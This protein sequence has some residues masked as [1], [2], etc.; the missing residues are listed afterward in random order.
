MKRI[1]FVEDD[2]LVARIYTPKLT[3]AG[4]EVQ[5]AEDGLLAVQRLREFKPDLVVLDLLMPKLGG[6]E[7]LKFIR[8]ELALKETRVIVFSNSFLGELLE[9]VASIGVEEALVKAS[10]TPRQLVDIINNVF[11]RPSRS[12]LAPGTVATN[13]AGFNE[14][15]AAASAAQ[16]APTAEQPI[17]SAPSASITKEK[18]ADHRA[19]DASAEKQ[20]ADQL[21]LILQSARK[22]CGEFLEAGNLSLETRKLEDLHR[23]IGFV[24]QALGMAGRRRLAHLAGALEAMLFDLQEKNVTV[25]D[26]NRHTIASAVAFL[27]ERIEQVTSEN[28]PPSPKKIL[29]V[30]DD[31]VSNRAAVLALNRAG[32][33]TMS[34]TDPFDTLKRLQSDSFGLVL[35]DINMPGMNGIAL[36]EQIRT[37]PSHKNTPV[38][39]VTGQSDFKTRARS[40]LSGGDDL[41]AKPI[42]PSELCVK[43]LEH[44]LT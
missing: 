34:I 31:Q 18:I 37:L 41:I 4:F 5:T 39:F 7:V 30:D 1:L 22:V 40:V 20:F 8:N 38:I 35:L 15:V 27:A 11:A 13:F 12:F 21:P 43:V 25:T 24:A 17:P 3:G 28:S 6:L 42:L 23:K 32:L 9:Q 33:P 14:T 10:V 29:I 2:A 16:T 19:A 44:L 36:C 26:S